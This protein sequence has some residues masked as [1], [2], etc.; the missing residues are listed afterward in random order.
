MPLIFRVRNS[1]Q[2][3]AVVVGHYSANFVDAGTKEHDERPRHGR[4]MVFRSKGNTIF[5]KKVH[6]RAHG[7]HRFKRL[8]AEEALR[9]HPM[10]V[11]LVRQWNEA[12]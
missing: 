8:A 9:R 10:A 3:K 7:P 1:T 4:A 2:R 6:K 5:A 11:E 12:A